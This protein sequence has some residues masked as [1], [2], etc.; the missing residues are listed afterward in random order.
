MANLADDPTS[1]KMKLVLDTIDEL[2]S[3][4]NRAWQD[5]EVQMKGIIG[6]R[7][8]DFFNQT[9]GLAPRDFQGHTPQKSLG[10]NMICHP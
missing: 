6:T 3:D 5:H 4:E 8:E 10:P 9:E 1:Q 7:P 2:I